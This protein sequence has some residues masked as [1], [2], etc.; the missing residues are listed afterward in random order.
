MNRLVLPMRSVR[1][2]Q[3]A[4]PVLAAALACGLL[5]WLALSR[6]RL[7]DRLTARARRAASR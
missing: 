6:S 2:M 1:P 4:W 5:E 7:A 3:P